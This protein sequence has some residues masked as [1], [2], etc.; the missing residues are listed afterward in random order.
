MMDGLTK[1]DFFFFFFLFWMNLSV[2]FLNST[3]MTRNEQQTKMADCFF[4]I[5]HRRWVGGAEHHGRRP[6][7]PGVRRWRVGGTER[8]CRQRVSNE[9]L[10]AVRR[11]RAFTPSSVFSGTLLF[12]RTTRG[13]L[14]S[15]Q[16]HCPGDLC[17]AAVAGERAGELCPAAVDVRASSARPPSQVTAR[18]SSAR[19]PQASFALAIGSSHRGCP[20]AA[21]PLD[22]D[23]RKIK[24]EYNDMW[25]SLIVSQGQNKQFLYHI[26]YV[27]QHVL[28]VE[29]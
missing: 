28:A 14:T 8:H 6:L 26:P 13:N 7:F 27:R 18:E 16:G 11:G 12:I 10:L 17:L 29:T 25:D 20:A 23:E 2:V 9:E 24:I 3:T 22:G 4:P 21:L 1:G 15:P 5:V 19:P